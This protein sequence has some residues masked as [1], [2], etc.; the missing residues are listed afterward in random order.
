[1]HMSDEIPSM[2]MVPACQR[3]GCDKPLLMFSDRNYLLIRDTP[4]SDPRQAVFC[5]RCYTDIT[6]KKP[7]N[8]LR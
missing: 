4:I 2:S 1:M 7:T 8:P 3:E 6:G 5:N